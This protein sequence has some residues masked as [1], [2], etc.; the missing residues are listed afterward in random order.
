MYTILLY[1]FMQATELR[2]IEFEHD[3]DSI[4]YLWNV[5][6][7]P[8]LTGTIVYFLQPVLCYTVG[9]QTGSIEDDPDIPLNGLR[10]FAI[11]FTVTYTLV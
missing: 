7:D 6:E 2:E 9:A 8:L 1:S 11:N 10:Y 5:H 3:K 4:P